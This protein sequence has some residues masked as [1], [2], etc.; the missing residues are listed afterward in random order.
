MHLALVVSGVGPGDEVICPVDVVYRDRN[1]IRHA[2]AMPVFA[3][4]NPQTYNLDPA[5]AE[6]AI[7]SRTKAILVVHQ[8]GL[9]A[10]LDRFFTL[11][12]ER[13]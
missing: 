3:E 2:G 4:V 12:E 11:A 13:V 8:I 9:P 10:D 5:A 7:T 1:S 6:A